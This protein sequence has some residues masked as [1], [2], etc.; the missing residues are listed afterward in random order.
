MRFLEF[1]RAQK[2]RQ[3]SKFSAGLA[4]LSP[5]TAKKNDQ[6]ALFLKND[7]IL[8]LIVLNAVSIKLA[9]NFQLCLICN[10]LSNARNRILPYR[11]V[12]AVGRVEHP[13][14]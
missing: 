1:E 14:H 2:I 4:L 10:A 7:E 9:E 3:N 8:F 11:P 12:V 5:R 13:V 6:K